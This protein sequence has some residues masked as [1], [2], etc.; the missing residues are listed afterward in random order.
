MAENK[1]I[2]GLGFVAK[3]VAPAV[4]AALK[5]VVGQIQDKEISEPLQGLLGQLE[6]VILL[7][8]DSD[9]DNVR[10]IKEWALEHGVST[11]QDLALLILQI[12]K[13]KG[14][15]VPLFISDWLKTINV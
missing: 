14:V 2:D 5:V 4:I 11:A 10:Q 3:W 9:K 12:L 1:K 6:R 8:S 13:T 7:L 15:Q